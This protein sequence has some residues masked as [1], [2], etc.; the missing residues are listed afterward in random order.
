MYH[1]KLV[2]VES[3]IAEYPE[4]SKALLSL[5]TVNVWKGVT[6]E[7]SVMIVEA[8]RRGKTGRHMICCDGVCLFDEE[9]RKEEFPFAE[10]RFKTPVTGYWGTGIVDEIGDIQAEINRQAEHIA[11][12]Q[13]RVSVPLVF[14]RNGSKINKAQLVNEIGAIV[15]GDEP[16]V[17]WTPQAVGVEVYNNIER[18]IQRA[19]EMVGISSLSAQAL[20]PSGLDSGRALREYN[21]IESER[22]AT[23][24]LAYEQFVIDSIQRAFD[25]LTDGDVISH[26]SRDGGLE[27]L[28]WA[29]IKLPKDDYL[30]QP[31]PTSALPNTPSGRLQ[32]IT[33]PL[34]C[35]LLDSSCSLSTRFL[36]MASM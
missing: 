16:P 25:L 31:F 4:H 1:V 7:P 28:K 29:D 12:C 34:R 6:V 11:E 15:N 13:R 30:M 14:V 17:I 23:L 33:A 35:H 19:Y 21:D 18:N 24:A 10:I 27:K 36:T 9:Y 32:I 3:L 20:K 22:F 8:W 26:G 2:G 5:D